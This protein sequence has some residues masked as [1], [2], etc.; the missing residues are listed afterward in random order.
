LT[1]R[2]ELARKLEQKAKLFNQVF[3]TTQGRLVLEMLTEDFCN[4]SLLDSDPLKMA[5]RVG[6]HDLVQYITDMTGA[7][8]G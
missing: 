7:P 6:Q 4:R 2:D 1:D 3:S 8:N 5:H